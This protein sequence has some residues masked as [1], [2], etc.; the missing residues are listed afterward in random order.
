MCNAG[1]REREG[2]EGETFALPPGP[3]FSLRPGARGLVCPAMGRAARGRG[4]RAGQ[5]GALPETKQMFSFFLFGFWC[6]SKSLG[7]KRG[8][9]ISV[10]VPA[11]GAR[12]GSFTFLSVLL[13]KLLFLAQ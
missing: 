3:P 1:A 10:Q 8:E 13:R 5:L 4:G 7:S 6:S 2:R 12:G 9:W 11:V